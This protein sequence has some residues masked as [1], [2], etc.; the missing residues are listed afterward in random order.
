MFYAMSLTLENLRNSFRL[1]R[2]FE[3]DKTFWKENTYRNE[4]QITFRRFL[5]IEH[6]FAY[7]NNYNLPRAIK[8]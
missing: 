6:K 7:N 5:M 1:R 4:R 2:M 3:T 8:S